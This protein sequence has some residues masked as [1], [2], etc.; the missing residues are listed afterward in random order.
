MQ[1]AQTSSEKVLSQLSAAFE[2]A[3][4]PCAEGNA[5]GFLS[6]L[7]RKI[8]AAWTQMCSTCQGVSLTQD[9]HTVSTWTEESKPA[10]AGKTFCMAVI[11]QIDCKDGLR[12][13]W[14]TACPSVMLS[15]WEPEVGRE[16]NIT[17]A[18]L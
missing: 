9:Q 4:R 6:A 1:I 7:R 15:R 18:M 14:N 8:V 2:A 10:I 17:S 13:Q 16:I 5:S 12:A 11:W 3:H